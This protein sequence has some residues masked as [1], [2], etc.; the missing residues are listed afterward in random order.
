MPGV[1]GVT[2]VTML[3]CFF[4]FAHKAAGAPSARHSLRPFDWGG[5]IDGSNPG[6]WRGGNELVMPGLD[7][8]IHQ[9]SQKAF[10]R[11]WIT[12]S[13]SAKT[14]FALLPGDDD[15]KTRLRCLTFA[16]SCHRPRRRTIQY[17]RDI[18]D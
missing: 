8:G 2:V 11:R 4:T 12:G 9:S 6:A 1:S 15:L 14:R 16:S 13:S 17:S 3:V 10:R 18:G 7:P 5:M